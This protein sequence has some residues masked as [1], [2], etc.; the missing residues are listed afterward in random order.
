M[1]VESVHLR[2]SFVGLERP[3]QFRGD[4]AMH[5]PVFHDPTGRRGRWT[6]WS[7]AAL[8]L[9]VVAAVSVLAFTIFEIPV[10]PPLPL[11]MEQARLHALAERIGAQHRGLRLF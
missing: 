4:S 9:L 7:F 1:T 2:A 10:P 8:V 3:P 5:K 6:G 11:R